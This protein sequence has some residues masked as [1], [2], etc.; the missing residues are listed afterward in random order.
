MKH[1]YSLLLAAGLSCIPAH[2][3]KYTDMAQK[4]L[5]WVK[6]EQGDSVLVHSIPAIKQ[7]LTSTQINA[8]WKQ[9][10]MQVGALKQEY[11]WEELEQGGLQIRR[12]VL[13]FERATLAFQA[14]F[15]KAMNLS[16]INF[17]PAK[18]PEKVQKAE[19]ECN[20]ATVFNEKDFSINH[21]KIVL[22]GTL[23]LPKRA[24][25][26]LPVV[27]LV[28]GSGPQDRDETLGPNKPFRD[29]AHAL[30]A[31]GIAV[32]RYDKRTKV[33]GAEFK[34]VS[35]GQVNYD[36][37]TVDDAVQAIRQISQMPGINPQ[38]IYVL[39]HSLGGML[40]PRIAE[41]SAVHLAGLIG[42]AASARPMEEM[43]DSQLSYIAEKQGTPEKE[44]AKKVAEAKAQLMKS[45][46]EEYSRFHQA[47]QPLKS[48]RQLKNQ[49]ML[50]LQ[51]GHDYQVTETD[52][53]LWKKATAGNDKAEFAFFEQ[54]DHLM[55]KLPQ[56]AVPQDYL[57]PGT[58]DAEVLQT[59]V[60]FIKS[61]PAQSH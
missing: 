59:I 57:Q 21:G 56:K 35:N 47:H 15:D 39:G 26:N 51:G 52:L 53:N 9:L 50:F 17:V 23:T 3:D 25:G 27:I 5:D 33:Y 31:Q 11:D 29:L 38:R 40:L 14:V 24:E 48:V 30:A 61:Q 18:A 42:M 28:H 55:R 36:T 19:T 45:I 13:A 44:I 41:K 2:A 10:N 34:T 7:V 4:H 60:R 43:L 12:K 22:P 1:V 16:G 49:R 58:M 8:L 54:C 20:T 32:L 6:H 37:E 46:P